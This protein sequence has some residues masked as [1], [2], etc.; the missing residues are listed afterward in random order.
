MYLEKNI[1][2]GRVLL[3]QALDAEVAKQ[4]SQSLRD[5]F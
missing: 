5:M 1:Y 4:L 3:K 2:K